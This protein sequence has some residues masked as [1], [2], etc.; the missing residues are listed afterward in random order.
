MAITDNTTAQEINTLLKW[1]LP[2]LK[3]RYPIRAE[4]IPRVEAMKA[5]ESLATKAHKQL[6]AGINGS[7]VRDAVQVDDWR[8]E[9]IDNGGRG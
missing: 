9:A 5:A 7:V 6:M 1:L 3:N 8:F 4:A 2:S